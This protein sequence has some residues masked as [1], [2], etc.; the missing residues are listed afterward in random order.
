VA[1]LAQLLAYAKLNLKYLLAFIYFQAVASG[2][3]IADHGPAET[4]DVF[5]L[6][7]LVSLLAVAG[8]SAAVLFCRIMSPGR[9][10]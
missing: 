6:A 7:I 8:V 4:G 3:G 10:G 2:V 5:I 1:Q 9:P